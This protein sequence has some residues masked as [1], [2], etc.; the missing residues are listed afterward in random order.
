MRTRKTIVILL[1]FLTTLSLPRFVASQ[2]GI[3]VTGADSVWSMSTTHS[4]D[5]VNAA[6]TAMPRVVAQYANSTRHYDL[7]DVPASLRSLIEVVTSRLV[8]DHANSTRHYDLSD[9]PASL[10]SLIE[11]VTPHLVIDHANSIR[12]YT[13]GRTP[14]ALQLLAEAMSPRVTVQYA[15]STRTKHLSYPIAL[16]NDTTPPQIS[17]IALVPISGD[18]VGVEWAT[19]EFATSAVLYG[20]QSGT[21][22][23]MVSDSL[24]TKQHEVVLSGLMAD[25][26]YYYIVRSTDRSGNS[27]TSEEQSFAP[28]G[29]DFTASPTTG[30][31]PLTVVFTN[32]STGGYDTSQWDF[33]DG[34]TGAQTNPTHVYTTSDV[35]T[36]T[37]TISGTSGTDTLVRTNCITVYQPVEAGFT[38][39][40]RT[41]EAPLVVQFTDASSGPVATWEWSFGDGATSALQHPTHTYVMTRTYTVSLTVRAAGGSAAWPGGTDSL[42]RKDYIAVRKEPIVYLPLTLRNH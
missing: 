10:R 33:G 37:L 40:P 21:Y 12:Q 18:S 14:G 35:Y 4:Q 26:T 23:Q 15:N 3:V 31:A 1:L 17:D 22:S 5:L 39:S 24:Y 29:A 20:T 25:T 36:V 13:L 38:A 7:N 11:V 42:V 30:F 2:S 19:D 41:G 8:I 6:S 32:T 34:A 28:L 9:V 27:A 16:M